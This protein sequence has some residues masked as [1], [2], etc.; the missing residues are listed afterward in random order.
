M[1]TNTQERLRE[2]ME[3]RQ[4]VDNWYDSKKSSKEKF[5]VRRWYGIS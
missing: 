1:M 4:P 2:I 3:T 5:V